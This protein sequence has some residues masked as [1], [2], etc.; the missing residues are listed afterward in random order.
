MNLTG[1]GQWRNMSSDTVLAKYEN[2]DVF[3]SDPHE[4]PSQ[5]R[6]LIGEQPYI[7]R[8]IIEDQACGKQYKSYQAFYAH[9]ETHYY[10]VEDKKYICSYIIG[11]EICGTEFISPLE[12]SE[13]LKSHD[14]FQ[15]LEQS[16]DDKKSVCDYIMDD[17][18]PCGK[19]VLHL[20]YHI[21]NIHT[22]QSK[23]ALTGPLKLPDHGNTCSV[24][25]LEDSSE[26]ETD[27]DFERN[28][29]IHDELDESAKGEDALGQDV[30]RR[31]EMVKAFCDI[32]G[33]ES[34][35]GIFPIF[36]NFFVPFH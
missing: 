26:S 27:A 11:D 8:E 20:K 15:L 5:E 29:E 24:E 12:L 23:V 31:M 34:G 6:T 21:K 1:N 33:P 3:V 10:Y 13:H 32:C 4:P 19:R 35:I 17:G 2:S 14:K 9:M 18:K 22:K 36:D 28:E 30:W 25:E 7:C 16:R